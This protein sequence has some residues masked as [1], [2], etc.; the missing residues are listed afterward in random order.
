MITRVDG[1]VKI[2][3]APP[4]ITDYLRYTHRGFEV[5]GYRKV[6]K[7]EQK[8]LYRLAEDGGVITFQGFYE[9]IVKLV[10]KHGDALQVADL[11]TALPQINLQAIKDINWAA[12]GTEGLRDYQ[13]DP[14]L[15]FLAK[16]Q[17]NSGIVN[18]TGGWGKTIF[19]AVTYAA[20]NKMNTILAI[21]I[22]QVFNQT[23]EKFV[24]LFPDKQ[25]GK[26][27][28]GVREL[29]PDITITTFNSLNSCA[30]E[31]CELL[32]VDE[33][34]S[35]TGPKT[36]TNFMSIKPVR[37]FGFTA[38]DQNFFNNADKVVKGMFGERLVYIPYEEAEEAKAVVP[39]LVYFVE[40]SDQIMIGATTIE[41]KISQGIKTCEERHRLIGKVCETVPAGWQTLIFVD[42]VADHLIRLHPH[43]PHGTKFVHRQ[44]DKRSLGAY[45]LTKKQQNVT[46]ADFCAN[47][48]QFLVA[49]DAFR[50]GVDIPN[51]R[52]VIQAAGGT[53]EVE[54][55]QEAFRGSR[56]LPA[57]RRDELGVDDKTH[58]VLIDF[59]DTHEQTLQ[60]MSLKRMEIY[61]KQGWKVRTVK[62]ARDIKWHDY[63][64]VSKLL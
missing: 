43:L 61:K 41:G 29:S 9:K 51:C 47:K 10:H 16:A 28:D 19:Q 48:F 14:V 44:S 35:V 23:Y 37:S 32:L 7:F 20:F 54:I 2:F 15:E 39:G 3:P 62:S 59:M 25:I 18:A 38:T 13:F 52:V 27:G 33:I 31:K 55:L 58:F 17:Q 22:K 34:Q 26:I 11:R 50:A 64:Q 21:P 1:A 57:S 36:L 12:I 45:A 4:Y 56:I 40:T 30:I 53:S 5:Q 8:F 63:R 42:H 24:E 49:T 46:I 6:N 60:N